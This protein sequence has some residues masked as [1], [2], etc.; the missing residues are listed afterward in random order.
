MVH[1]LQEGFTR[2][3]EGFEPG[4]GHAD[5]LDALACGS[6]DRVD[7]EGSG[8]RSYQGRRGL[9][10]DVKEQLWKPIWHG[11]IYAADVLMGE[12]QWTH[13]ADVDYELWKLAGQGPKVHCRRKSIAAEASIL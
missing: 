13:C 9:F 12:A 8:G 6:Q 4:G 7:G 3:R 5:A 1:F 10:W 2:F 11:S